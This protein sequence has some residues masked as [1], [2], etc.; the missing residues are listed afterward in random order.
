VYEYEEDDDLP[1][2]NRRPYSSDKHRIRKRPPPDIRRNKTKSGMGYYDYEDPSK[3]EAASNA[4]KD[5]LMMKPGNS[6]VIVFA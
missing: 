3:Y 4:K 5:L 2:Y 6:A 1:S